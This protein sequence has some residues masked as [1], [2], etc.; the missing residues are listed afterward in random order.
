MVWIY[1]GG[2]AAGAT[3]EA[4][5]GRR[6]PVQEGRAGGVHELPAGH[7]R[8]FLA[9]G[10]GQGIGARR[11]GELRADGPGRG[12]QMG[13]RQHRGIR[14]RSRQ[15][16]DFRR[17]GGLVFGQ[18]AD[19]VAARAGTVPAGHRRERRLLWRY[20]A[21]ADAHRAEK[22]GCGICQSRAGDGFDRG[23]ARQTCD[24]DSAGCVES[25][26]SGAICAQ[27]RWLL[28]AGKRGGDLCR[29]QAESRAA[30]GRVERR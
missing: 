13:A 29:R 7:L 19:G 30:A 6:Q 5:P 21:A 25:R 26:R 8:V 23:V 24:R 16:H 9:S 4:A 2:F 1:G 10:A 12:P 20:A 17:I 22:A 3:S 18:R 11:G 15:C 27:H 14:R 28:P